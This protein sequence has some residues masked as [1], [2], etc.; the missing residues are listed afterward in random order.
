MINGVSVL[1]ERGEVP[2]A[3]GQARAAVEWVV[4][5]YCIPTARSASTLR[6]L[7]CFWTAPRNPQEAVA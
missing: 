3:I 4:D 2:A 1:T 7:C 6:I 5:C